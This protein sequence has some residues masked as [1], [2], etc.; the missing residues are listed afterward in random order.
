[1]ADEHAWKP[2]PLT[3]AIADMRT[4]HIMVEDLIRRFDKLEM[5]VRKLDMQQTEM[6][7]MKRLLY[8]LFYL[9]LAAVIGA[10][11]SFVIHPITTMVRP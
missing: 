8:G 3:D 10:L 2:D 4:V 9:V 6:M 5:L 1:M 11:L 7:P